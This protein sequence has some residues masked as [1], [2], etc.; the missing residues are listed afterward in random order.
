MNRSVS[1]S[2]GQE[3]VPTVSI[4]V[5]ICAYTTDRWMQLRAA[6]DSA[7][8]QEPVPNEVVVVVDHCQKLEK[9]AREHLG[10]IG[11]TVVANMQA[12]GLSGARNTGCSVAVGDIV[13][14]LDDD[15]EAEA[16]WLAA[17][18]ELYRDARVMGVGGL[19]EPRWESR[20]PRWFPPEFGWVVG[21][22]YL[23]QP[24]GPVDVR[25]PIG[26]NMSFRREVIESI[27]GFS[28]QL[29]RVG[30]NPVGCEETEL[31]I[32]A[33]RAYPRGRIV[34]QPAAVVRH[35]VP[36]GRGRWRYFRRRCWSEGR[37]KAWV[38]ELSDPRAALSSE[39]NYVFKTLP[40]GVA[41]EVRSALRG[42]DLGYLGRAMAIFAGLTITS[43]GYLF[44]RINNYDTNTI[45]TGSS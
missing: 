30:S 36:D 8:R 44:G 25:N 18:A 10:R 22:S 31:S 9:L 27:G 13:V 20:P 40:S 4:T 16:G 45:G 19:V 39:T 35:H 33:A 38:S 11:V 37:S 7:L 43:A 21:C 14:F 34:H 28:E 6:V 42:P 24:Q 2:S 3:S 32:R 29:G 12:R 5:V 17:H 41:R 15:A 26:A 1:W 23:G